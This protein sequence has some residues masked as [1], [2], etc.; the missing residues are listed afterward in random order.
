ML[1]QV[2]SN[3]HLKPDD[4]AYLG[5]KTDVIR[6]ALGEQWDKFMPI[7]LKPLYSRSSLAR[8]KAA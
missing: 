6:T 4:A 7:S 1:I 5:I 3:T 8:A 2:T